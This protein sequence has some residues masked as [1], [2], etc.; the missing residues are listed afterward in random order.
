MLDQKIERE[1]LVLSSRNPHSLS[2][3]SITSLDLEL[4]LGSFLLFLCGVPKGN[5]RIGD[6]A[7]RH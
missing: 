5:Q 2:G 4:D 6:L 3:T 7:N 1:S